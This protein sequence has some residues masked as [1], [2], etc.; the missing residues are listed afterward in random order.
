MGSGG[1]GTARRT[2]ARADWTVVGAPAASPAPS[3]VGG[4]S[5]NETA[6]VS[7]PT[8][9]GSTKSSCAWPIP[10]P[11]SHPAMTSPPSTATRSTARLT[12]QDAPCAPPASGIA[13]T[14][15]PSTLPRGRPCAG[16]P[17]QHAAR[18][19]GEPCGL[20]SPERTS[21]E[22]TSPE[23]PGIHTTR[24]DRNMGYLDG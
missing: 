10:N 5:I 19:P 9:C 13:V 20:I 16:S 14:G 17:C 24:C 11:N 4:A 3:S 23:Q 7:C 21:P 18:W 2:P 1:A 15:S 12:P 6:L 22:L 8:L